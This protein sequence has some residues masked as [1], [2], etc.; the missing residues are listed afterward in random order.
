MKL[1]HFSDNPDIHIFEPRIIYNR[2]DEPP[3]VWTIDEKHAPH[4]YF[5]RECPRVCVWPKEDTSDED[6]D[7]FFGMS[8]TH[9]MVAI[10][11]GWYDR[12][13]RGHICRYSFDPDGFELHVADAGY[14]I[15]TRPVKPIGVERIDDLIGSLLQEGIELRVTPSLMPLR[16]RILSSTVNFSM[17]RMRNAATE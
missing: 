6:I 14:Y 4:Y 8:K 17:I 12:V 9:R 10:E 13:R 11:I 1:Y 15:T 5:P 2:T 3:K 16:E 7:L